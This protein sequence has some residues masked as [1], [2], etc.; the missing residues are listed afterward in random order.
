MS[1]RRQETKNLRPPQKSPQN[2]T[3]APG[4]FRTKMFA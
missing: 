1:I 4:R 2:P 3:L